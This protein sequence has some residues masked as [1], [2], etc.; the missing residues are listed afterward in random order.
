MLS[1]E[2]FGHKA[3]FPMEPMGN[4]L[5]GAGP[6]FGKSFEATTTWLP[7]GKA[8]PQTLPAWL[9][10]NELF[11]PPNEHVSNAY[12]RSTSSGPA[13]ERSPSSTSPG[14]AVSSSS[15]EPA[16]GADPG[17]YC[18]RLISGALSLMEPLSGNATTCYR[19]PPEGRRGDHRSGA[20]RG[21]TVFP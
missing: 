17:G 8:S 11:E 1:V 18:A 14:V 20:Q 5:V 6:Q 21:T 19:S 9:D 3:R 13:G 2:L 4:L 16:D 12:G 10:Y 15:D 7:T